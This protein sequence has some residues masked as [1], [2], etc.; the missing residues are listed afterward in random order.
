[1]PRFTTTVGA[2]TDQAIEERLEPV[3]PAIDTS[4]AL[5]ADHAASLERA[6]LQ[7]VQREAARLAFKYGADSNQANAASEA[8]RNA[9]RRLAAIN[10]E[11]ERTR[12]SGVEADP[13][14]VVLHGR[15]LD[16]QGRG[17]PKLTVAIVDPVGKTTARTQTDE[18]GYFKLTTKPIVDEPE[19]GG[20]GVRGNVGVRKNRLIVLD[21]KREVYGEDLEPLA[22]GQTR[23]RE[24][25]LT[26]R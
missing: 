22:A 15:V 21:G 5:V 14:G 2:A 7:G 26:G 23:Y 17:Q 1:M 3:F 18:R 13:K 24:I 9:E 12:A 8:V 6:H 20:G 19:A 25:V 11:V 10:L 16:A 4:R